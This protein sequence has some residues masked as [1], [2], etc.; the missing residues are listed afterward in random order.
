MQFLLPF[1]TISIIVSKAEAE[2]RSVGEM[3]FPAALFTNNQTLLSLSLYYWSST[4]YSSSEALS[5][6]F[7][8]GYTDVSGKTLNYGVRGVKSF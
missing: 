3:K 7:L 4:E 5:Y 8:T 1:N 2:S 6:D